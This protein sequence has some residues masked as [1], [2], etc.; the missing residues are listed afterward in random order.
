MWKNQCSL[1]NCIDVAG[2][3]QTAQVIEKTGR[4]EWFAIVA[5]LGTE[6][7][8]FCFVKMERA[9]EIDRGREPARDREF[10][11]KRVFSKSYVEYGFVITHSGIPIAA[12]HCN[13]VK[14][15]R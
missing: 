13:F 12:C 10:T 1:R 8:K 15:G 6:I 14:I 11:T 3:S 4:E 2:Q 9:Y 5:A 7:I